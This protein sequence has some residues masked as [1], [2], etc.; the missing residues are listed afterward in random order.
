[1]SVD[2]N[3]K[4]TQRIIDWKNKKKSCKTQTKFTTIKYC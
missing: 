1:M 4:C 3:K 2:R